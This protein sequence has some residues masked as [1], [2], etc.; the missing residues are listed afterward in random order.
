[1]SKSARADMVKGTLPFEEALKKLEG[2]VEAM[3]SQ[4]LP[5]EA[6][7][8]RYEEGTRL[9][10][11]CQEK[12]AEAELKIRQLEKDAAGELKLKPFAGEVE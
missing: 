11:V 7:L 1:M 12:L 10:K 2:V 4:D 9:V 6:L 8:A 3:E 5:L